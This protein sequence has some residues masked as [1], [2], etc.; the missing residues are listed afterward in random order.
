MF[1]LTLSLKTANARFI[2]NFVVRLCA[3]CSSII[4][5][6]SKESVLKVKL[7]WSKFFSFRCWAVHASLV[8]SPFSLLFIV[9]NKYEVEPGGTRQ[10][11]RSVFYFLQY[12]SHPAQ[13]LSSV[14]PASSK[15][16]GYAY[17]STSINFMYLIHTDIFPY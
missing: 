7:R 8:A 2:L 4:A 12:L 16:S 3:A 1:R 11:F 15:V 13:F 5:L 10:V 14:F 6:G 17:I 9:V